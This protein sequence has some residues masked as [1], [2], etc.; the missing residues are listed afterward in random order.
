M[1]A[2]DNP[3]VAPMVNVGKIIGDNIKRI[4]EA[5]YLAR[6]QKK[7]D[8]LLLENGA[9]DRTNAFERESLD[10]RRKETSIDNMNE[11]ASMMV[12]KYYENEKNYAGKRVDADEYR[13]IRQNLWNNL[14]QY[15]AFQKNTATT[16]VNYKKDSEEGLVSESREGLQKQKR[17]ESF[18]ARKATIVAG[19]DG[20]A[21]IKVYYPDIDKETKKEITSVFEKPLEEYV[22]NPDLLSYDKKA[23]LKSMTKTMAELA[24]S[25]LHDSNSYDSVKTGNVERYFYNRDSAKNMLTSDD[26]LNGFVAANLES[27]VEDYM[28]DDKIFVPDSPSTHDVYVKQLE[29][30]KDWYA[31]HIY[32]QGLGREVGRKAIPQPKSSKL[33]RTTKIKV[34]QDVNPSA[35]AIRKWDFDNSGLVNID[36]TLSLH[37]T[38]V[39][40]GGKPFLK[41]APGEELNDFK[42]RLNIA[43]GYIKPA[44][45]P[46]PVK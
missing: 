15:Q 29:E 40:K 7:N 42:K 25:N 14:N 24:K 30:A 5:D 44:A 31:D 11:V 6:E 4:Q 20:K 2:Y 46:S 39:F 8:K 32:Q 16:I 21:I 1:G 23:D 18:K 12:D 34:D 26:D 38:T 28:P 45:K 13:R 27:I 43:L 41:M 33:P 17:L 9:I 3:A 36:A 10:L 35:D 37:G 19:D 22:N